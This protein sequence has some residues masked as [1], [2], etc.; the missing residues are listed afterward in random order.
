MTRTRDARTARF[1]YAE[2]LFCC[3]RRRAQQN[4][5]HPSRTRAEIAR[6]GFNVLRPLRVSAE[7]PPLPRRLLVEEGKGCSQLQ[8]FI[9]STMLSLE[10]PLPQEKAHVAGDPDGLSWMNISNSAPI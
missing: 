9:L 5:T 1:D 10:E 2:R 3:T 4:L 6:R 8:S 7:P